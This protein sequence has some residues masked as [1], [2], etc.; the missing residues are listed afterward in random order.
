MM[1]NAAASRE[2]RYLDERC[3]RGTKENA[4]YFI[5]SIP[6][7]ESEIVDTNQRLRFLCLHGRR[8]SAEIMRGQTMALRHYTQIDCVFLDAPYVASGP[9]D[10]MIA[11]IYPDSAYLE[12]FNPKDADFS[13]KLKDSLKYVMDFVEIY[14]PFDGVIGFSQGA[15][16]ATMLM[17]TLKQSEHQT[18]LPSSCVLIGGVD[19]M[20][21]ISGYPPDILHVNSLHIM[22]QKDHVFERSVKLWEMYAENLAVKIE[23]T[24]AHNI[25]SVKTSTYHLIK[26]WL[27]EVASGDERSYLYKI[28]ER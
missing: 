15:T 11:M 10:D 2:F 19:P 4:S 21:Y 23:H 26:K 6:K 14:G 17:S 9:A 7:D 3:D 24:E 12:W 20:Y 1:G 5:S 22:G 27:W 8:T 28:V 16:L 18:K 25:P 13:H